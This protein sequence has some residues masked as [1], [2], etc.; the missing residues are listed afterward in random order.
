MWRELRHDRP[1]V[2]LA[3][4]REFEW[5]P[6]LMARLLRCRLVLEVHSP[7][8]IEEVLRGGHAS[9]ITAWM[10]RKMFRT[11]DLIWVHT[12][13]LEVLVRDVAPE[14]VIQLAPFGIE[15]RGLLAHPGATDLPTE[16]VFVGSFY[17]WHGVEDLV[18]AFALAR[19]QV[20]ELRLSLV[21]DGITRPQAEERAHRLGLSHAVEFPGW[22]DQDEMYARLLRAHIGVAPY[23]D[24]KYNY[25]EPVKIRDY[26]MVGLPIVATAVGHIPEMVADGNSGL[27][28]PAGDV[29][30]M[31]AA[32]VDLATDP[33][34]RREM[35]RAS[36][37]SAHAIEETAE[38]VV[39]MCRSVA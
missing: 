28:I 14:A 35:G 17:N 18:E 7:F 39:E 1:E 32:L 21:G 5:T 31:A 26:Q 29:E 22:L 19:R 8:A 13:E 27:L 10:D 23:R 11:A 33:G 15:D 9:R 30:A 38:A 6:L 24:S 25:F 3:R 12:P 2:L 36:R 16:I 4:Y 34:L 37:V 20:P